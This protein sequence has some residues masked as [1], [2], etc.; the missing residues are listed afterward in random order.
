MTTPVLGPTPPP[1][2]WEIAA[3]W[4]EHAADLPPSSAAAENDSASDIHENVAV[5]LSSE[6]L[7]KVL[8]FRNILLFP[9]SAS[10]CYM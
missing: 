2:Q 7:D 8:D 9:Q 10:I 4:P 5:I 3:K 6:Q 1:N